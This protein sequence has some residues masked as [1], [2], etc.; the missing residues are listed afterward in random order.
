MIGE[1]GLKL[2]GGDVSFPSVDSGHGSG[3][4]CPASVDGLSWTEI[5]TKLA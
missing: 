2:E 5:G 4:F 3:Y 1:V